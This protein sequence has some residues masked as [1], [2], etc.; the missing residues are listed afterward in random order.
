MEFSEDE[1]EETMTFGKE[2]AKG[3]EKKKKKKDS[4][5]AQFV[6]EGEK[7]AQKG[8]HGEASLLFY[9]VVS[10]DNVDAKQWIPEAR[11]RLSRALLKMKMYQSA[12][13]HLKKIAGEGESHPYFSPSIRGLMK[14]AE[15]MPGSD[16]VKKQLAAYASQFPEGIPESLRNRYAYL[17]GRYFHKK[18]N[19][20]EAVRLLDAVDEG[21]EYYL[22][23][24]YIKA[25]THV[26][27][28]DAKPALKT[29][30]GLLG[31]L[32]E[33]RRGK[34][35][36]AEQ[37]KLFE[38]VNLG[39]GR[40]FYST[41]D[42]ETS[43]KYYDAVARESPRWPQSLLE[44]SW[45]RF[46]LDEY[47][48]ALGNLHSLNSPFF[49]D[50]YNPEGPILSSVIY[51]YNCKYD[52]VRHELDKFERE[53]KPIKKGLKRILDEQSDAS[54]MF[55]WYQAYRNGQVELRPRV[56]A[57]VDSALA[58]REVGSKVQVVAEID[59]EKKRIQGQ[60]ASWRESSLGQ[61]VLQNLSLA[62]SFAVDR[63]GSLIRQRLDR[64][65]QKLKDLFNQKKKILFEVARA[66]RGNIKDEI[67]AGM[68]IEKQ[69][70]KSSG[71]A[72][73]VSDKQ[74]Y[75]KFRGEYWRDEL[76][77]YVFDVTSQCQ[78]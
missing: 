34:G 16:T 62:R 9:K 64:A 28:Y 65:H 33:R 11:Y 8:K 26:A 73:A 48:R 27:N 68:E 52:R 12:L 75:W 15:V 29:F 38:L 6:E 66:E 3:G 67:R 42:Y 25:V 51:F 47:N 18:L 78:R 77:H 72:V 17:T 58:D 5:A 71:R 13:S 37:R 70:K 44:S 14:V 60:P 63:A 2:A 1:A 39:M 19:V 69:K 40:L 22:R 74:M 24:Q 7:L 59:R 32:I 56:R 31:R 20:E 50:S 46:Q 49:S 43:L 41:G 45:A 10:Q 54:S 35:L 55:D 76:G 36:N 21:S 61:K 4:P 57:T 23:A 53:Y 30:K